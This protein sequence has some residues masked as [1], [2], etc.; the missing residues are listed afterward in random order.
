MMELPETIVTTAQIN[1]TLTGKKI[2]HV[3]NATKLHRFAFFHGDPK[4]YEKILAGKIIKSATGYGMFIDLVL[5]D[6]TIIS[7]G[8]GANMKYRKP[9]DKIPGSYQLLIGFED[10]SFLVFSI[11]LYGFIGVYPDGVIDEIYH[12][13]N[14]ENLS[15]LQKTF[16]ME[17]FS[18]LIAQCSPNLSVKAL[19]ATEQRLP[20]IGN[21]VLQDIL[22]K[23]KMNPK[24]KIL[25]LDITEKEKL[26]LT[27]KQ[28]LQ[29]M[30]L[31]GGRDVQNDLFGNPG[32]YHTILSSKTYKEP[33]PVCG[34]CIRK[35]AYMG[36]TVY[37]CPTCQPLP[38]K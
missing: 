10:N 8:E 4:E 26:Y 1:D 19:L 9:G 28:T 2:T 32:K 14:K 17:Y 11:S 21:G 18:T 12:K 29:E 6:E 16:S 34:S 23:A 5:N 25:T 38:N 27:I 24:R 33:C 22:F 7:V 13:Q 36:G 35:E 30:V 20:G 31:K 3:F 37:Y 15:P